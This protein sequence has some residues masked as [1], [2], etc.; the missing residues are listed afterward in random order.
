MLRILIA[1]CGYVGQATAGLL[2]ERGWKVEGW[3]ASARSAGQLAAKPYAVR[4]VDMTDTAAVSDIREEFD[5]VVHCAS[6]AG[7]GA[8]EYRRIYLE[9]VRTLLRAF[10]SAKLLFTSST[11]VYAQQ[12]G[13]IVDETSPAEPAHERGRIL[14]EAEEVVLSHNGIVTRLGGIY[15]PGRSFLLRR[16]LAGE[17]V[18]DYADDR[19][20]NQAHR[21]DIASALFLLVEQQAGLG[22]QIY[23]V[24]DGQPIRA[25]DAYEWLSAHLQRPL[26][27]G[28]V[29]AGRKRG[30]SNKR[31][32][33]KKLR[34]LGW[35]PR[36]PNFG[37]AM[38]ESV[39][40]SFGFTG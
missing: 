25:H 26:P 14:R 6:S 12:H 22:C 20:I 40:P 1:G 11:S 24:V 3:T 7:G 2:H 36:Y 13:N 28:K 30:D 37:V 10:P 29:A 21:D 15:G 23:N 17:A 5:L 18:L 27:I 34:A 4:A 9:G 35:K 31:V 39:L 16:F 19:F 8:E 38:T 32:S 33:N